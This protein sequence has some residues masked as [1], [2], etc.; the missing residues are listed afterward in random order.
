MWKILVITYLACASAQI[1][2]FPS[3]PAPT[4]AAPSNQRPPVNNPLPDLVWPQQPQPTA[5]PQPPLIPNWPQPQPTPAPQPNWPQPQ[6]Q[7]TRAPVRPPISPPRPIPPQNNQPS[8][9]QG[10]RD[11]RC[12]IPDGEFP[13]FF[14]NPSNCR[15]YFMCSSG[16]AF[17]MPCPSSVT[18]NVIWNSRAN[19][20]EEVEDPRC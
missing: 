1:P 6:P 15:Q 20:C 4:T 5:A 16:F 18:N 2:T 7:P 9:R 3:F 19:A 12:P 8:W 13:T 11:N 17:P 10:T 14:A